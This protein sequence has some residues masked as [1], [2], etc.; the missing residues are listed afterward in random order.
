[1]ERSVNDV[2]RLQTLP[3]NKDLCKL[4]VPRKHNIIM[5]CS[6]VHLLTKLSCFIFVHLI[7]II[8]I[9]FLYSTLIFCDWHWKTVKKKKRTL[10]RL[11]SISFKGCRMSV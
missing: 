7:N 10:T 6:T 4:F 9:Y 1:M 3:T 2:K 8:R 5:L 11:T